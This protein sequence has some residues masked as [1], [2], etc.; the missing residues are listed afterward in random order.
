MSA[1]TPLA[2]VLWRSL[3]AY[4]IFGANTEVGKTVFTTLLCRGAE[5]E[6]ERVA[7]L[8][9]VSTGPANEADD[10]CELE[11][12]ND[13]KLLSE[14]RTLISRKPLDVQLEKQQ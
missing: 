10:K 13:H 12:I 3:R 2:S 7:F 9:P 5:K 6:N 8:K 1:N 14:Y 11:L 4:Q